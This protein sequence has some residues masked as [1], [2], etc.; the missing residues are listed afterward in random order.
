[1]QVDKA[2]TTAGGLAFTSSHTIYDVMTET[3][4]VRTYLHLRT[5]RLAQALCNMLKHIALYTGSYDLA[6]AVS[7]TR[8]H[9]NTLGGIPNIA[10]YVRHTPLARL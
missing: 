10:F 8:F 2:Q 4:A 6:N 5:G 9:S 7:D 3:V 1:M